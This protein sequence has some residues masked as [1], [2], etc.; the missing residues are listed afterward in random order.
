MNLDA[1]MAAG[2]HT[3]WYDE[4]YRYVVGG[5]STLKTETLDAATLES[6]HPDNCDGYG[7]WYDNGIWYLDGITGYDSLEVAV[8]VGKRRKELAIYDS[9]TGTVIRL[10]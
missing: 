6:Y 3:H 2:G 10:D 1:I 8:K 4:E 9:E 7:M 5:I